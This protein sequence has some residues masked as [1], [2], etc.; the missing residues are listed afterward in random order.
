MV[1]LLVYF[2]HALSSPSIALISSLDSGATKDFEITMIWFWG[3][4]VA[5]IQPRLNAGS[6][7]VPIPSISKIAS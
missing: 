6:F 3:V 5:A 7:N 1:S 4:C 2:P